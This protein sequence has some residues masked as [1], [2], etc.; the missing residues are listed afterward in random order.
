MSWTADS[1]PEIQER[2]NDTL[3]KKIVMWVVIC[4]SRE[5]WP[6]TEESWM[7]KAALKWRRRTCLFP[8]LMYWEELAPIRTLGRP[9][10]F[11][12]SPMRSQGKWHFRQK[13]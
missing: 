13:N 1:L 12:C 4:L 6:S 5:D 9:A 10:Q 7:S 2:E 3:D 8:V 11:F